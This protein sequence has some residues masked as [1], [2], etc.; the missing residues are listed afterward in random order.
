MLKLIAL[1]FLLAAQPARGHRVEG[2]IHFT[3]DSP[4]DEAVT[5]EL[6]TRDRRQVLFS[7]RPRDMSFEFA[8]LRPAL[9]VLRL[10]WRECVLDYEVDARRRRETDVRV[11]MDAACGSGK[12]GPDDVRPQPP[13]APAPAGRRVVTGA[14][15]FTN[16][17]PPER[18][19]L[20]QLYTYEI[21]RVV[22][23]QYRA[24]ESGF[25]FE[26]LAPGRY[27]LHVSGPYICNLWYEV[28]ARRRQETE[29]TILG[30]ADC[31]SRGGPPGWGV[32]G[33]P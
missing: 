23:E 13:P 1:T 27:F 25:R 33:R 26:N 16:N 3:N 21:G 30:D 32:K 12:Y 6:L 24:G 10:R 15:Y 8:W 4:P 28:D 14:V 31:G 11:V 22:A 2:V 17:T 29:L 20:F 18:R 19:Y 7:K 9:Y 5:V